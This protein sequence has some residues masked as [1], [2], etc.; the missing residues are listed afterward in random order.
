MAHMEIQIIPLNIVR[1]KA[2][3]KGI[4][5]KVHPF[6]TMKQW[7]LAI[8]AHLST[9]EARKI[10]LQGRKPPTLPNI[11]KRM[12]EMMIQM[13]TILVVVPQEEIGGRAHFIT[14]I[15]IQNFYPILVLREKG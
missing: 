3:A 14:N 6:I 2:V 13:E 11:S 10:I 8:S 4:K 15:L 9:M 7:N 12:G 1:D 5:T